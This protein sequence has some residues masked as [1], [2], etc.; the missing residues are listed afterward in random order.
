MKKYFN[1]WLLTSRN[2]FIG[3]LSNRLGSVFF[4]LGK[5]FRFGSFILFIVFL[6]KG[7]KLLAGYNLNQTIFFFL[8][9]SFIDTFSQFLFRE[10]YRFRPQIVEG[11]FDL[12]LTKPVSALFQSLMGGADVLDLFTLP[13]LIVALIYVGQKL[14]PDP[15]GIL[16]YVL[17]L[18]NG[19]L[20]SASFHIIILSLGII[21]MEID[22]T[23]L[24]YRDFSSLARFPIDIYKEPLKTIITY[25]LPIGV[26]IS[27]PVKSLLSLV[28]F[29]GIL[30]S[31]LA[32]I[33]L[34]IF[35]GRFWDYALRKYSSA[36][37]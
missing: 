19:M 31:F 30:F 28:S 36:S 15:L 34:F 17:L 11:R 10:T 6:L 27:I 4:L 3:M 26:M 1:I 5:L 29:W 2:S 22:H 18:A 23:V 32:G 7:T 9:Y 13:P 25:V 12:V 16:F 20:I 14:S 24:I 37:S 33:V 35:A 21:S 8:T